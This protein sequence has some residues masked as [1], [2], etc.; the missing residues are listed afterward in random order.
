MFDELI[1]E[2]RCYLNIRREFLLDVDQPCELIYY[3]VNE[4]VIQ[5]FAV[6]I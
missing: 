5:A 1:E 2:G 6:C 4:L 3:L